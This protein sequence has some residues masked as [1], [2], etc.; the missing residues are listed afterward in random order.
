A[1]Q[2]LLVGERMAQAFHSAGV[3]EDVFQNL[4]LSHDTTSELISERA[5]D[6]VNFTGSVGGGRAMEQAAAGTFTPVATELGGKDPGYVME[7]ADLDAAVDT[8]IDGAMFN[9]GQCCC[10]IER[11]YVHES[12]FD[13]FVEKAVKVVEGY[14]LGNPLDEATTIGP[15]ANVRFAN[16]VRAQIDEA[17]AAGADRKSTRLNS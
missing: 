8:L 17:V 15:M 4:F 12:L 7:D 10:G 11:I 5:V 1:T 6:F 2:T 14:T 16:E 9:S 3:P 13:A